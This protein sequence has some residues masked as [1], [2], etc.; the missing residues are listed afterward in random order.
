MKTILFTLPFLFFTSIVHAQ[1][2]PAIPDSLNGWDLSWAAGLNGSQA[3]YSNWA[4][5]GVNN[6]SVTGNSNFDAL[7]KEN[8]FSY[9]FTFNTRYGKSK[10]QDEGIRKIDDRL[11]V[12]NRFLYDLS[13]D[14]DGGDFKLF[15]NLNLRTQFDKGFDYG[16]GPNGEDIL[17]S[18][19]FAP[20]YLSENAGL[21][22]IPD[23]YFS[24]EAGL[25][26]QQTF[27]QD[28]TLSETYGLDAGETF[29]NEAGLTF[30]ANYNRQVGTNV[31]IDSGL[32]L[33]TNLNRALSSTDVLFRNE[34]TGRI[35]S[36]MNASIRFDL[37][38]DDDFSNEI[39]VAQILSIGISFILI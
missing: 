30:A 33:F 18:R 8:R 1:D 16:A 12:R 25:G 39:Q 34:L 11:S 23:E 15:G 4:P 29:R 38:Y 37:A 31:S 3:S 20:A 27:V 13:D 35:N 24:V 22:Y 6:I 32:E 5:G 26:L 2:T 14:E 7:F 19:F 36:L 21:A 9:I 28:E 17:I 10:V